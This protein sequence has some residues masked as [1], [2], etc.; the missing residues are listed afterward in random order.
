M[1]T[2]AYS[3]DFY[4]KMQRYWT[5]RQIATGRPPTQEEM[6]AA[7]EA[8]LR[9]AGVATEVLRREKTQ[10]DQFTRSLEQQKELAKPNPTQTAISALGSIG[11]LA[12]GYSSL[13][14]S[15]LIG[16][17]TGAAGTTG[18]TPASVDITKTPI[19]EIKQSG[20]YYSSPTLA[21]NAMTDA[22]VYGPAEAIPA[23][24]SYVVSPATWEGMSFTGEGIGAGAIEGGTG[25]TASLTPVELG[26][27]AAGGTS[28]S[29]AT[30]PVIGAIIA[31]ALGIKG[32][33]QKSRHEQPSLMKP[34]DYFA[35]SAT[36]PVAA[37]TSPGAILSDTGIIK[38]DTA[39]GEVASFT[40]KA[41]EW[42]MD[43]I[44]GGGK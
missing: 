3:T 31:A 29:M 8:G 14:N 1:A 23:G 42:F 21:Q 41:E 38:R 36:H 5:Q 39:L 7:M 33:A 20:G 11:S 25:A 30:V 12:L 17:K 26:G 15:G 18:A 40:G 9:E 2:P 6:Q 44:T 35:E 32:A 24:S 27:G 16:G 19:S 37:V 43:T 28:S 10:E 13:K 34:K 4:K 22:S